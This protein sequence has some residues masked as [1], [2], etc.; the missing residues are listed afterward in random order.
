[1]KN[2]LGRS[3]TSQEA[4][5]PAKITMEV[6]PIMATEMPSTPMLNRMF[7]LSY[8]TQLLVNSISAVLPALRSARKR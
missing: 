6:S 1:M 4:K 7:R 3:S 8:Q 2:S 5:I